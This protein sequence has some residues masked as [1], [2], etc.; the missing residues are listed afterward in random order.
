MNVD[1]NLELQIHDERFFRSLLLFGLAV[2]LLPLLL[3]MLLYFDA[4]VE[5]LLII[6]LGELAA[7]LLT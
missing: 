7:L 4:A 6:L 2:L 1:D 5:P 3:V